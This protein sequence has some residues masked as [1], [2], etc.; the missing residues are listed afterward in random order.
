MLCAKDLHLG[1]VRLAS[2]GVYLSEFLVGGVVNSVMQYVSRRLGGM[3]FVGRAI[4]QL[5][6]PH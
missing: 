2:W 1:M 3:W 6:L 4:S 5:V